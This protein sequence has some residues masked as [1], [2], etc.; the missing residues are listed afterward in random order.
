MTEQTRNEL[1]RAAGAKLS[2]ELSQFSGSME[3]QSL[4]P[5]RHNVLFTEGA[6]YAAVKGNLFW[7]MNDIAIRMGTS[8]FPTL[9]GQDFLVWKLKM[10]TDADGPATLTA[11]DG[12][13][14]ELLKYEYELA[15]CPMNELVLWAENNGGGMTVMLPNER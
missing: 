8:E 5:F 1:R 9:Y 15:C 6:T 13:G 4:C 3:F 7:L 14:N 2:T 10:H 11:E 12:N